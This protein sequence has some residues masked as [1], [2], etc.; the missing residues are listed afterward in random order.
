VT[1]RVP[2]KLNLHLGVHAARPDGFH[3]LH[4]VF[5]AVA[6]FDQVTA[7]ESRGLSLE[8][9]GDSDGVPGDASNLAWRAAELLAGEAGVRPDVHLRVHKAIPVAGGMAGGSADA[10]GALV[11]CAALWGVEAD[12]P[13]LAARLGSDVAFPLLGGTAVGTGRGEVLRPVACAPLHWVLAL[14]GFGISAGDAY[15]ELDRLRAAGAAAAPAGP[16]PDALLAAL[17]TGD[18]ERIGALLGN[19]LQAA[20][21]S[22]VPELSRTLELGL[23]AGAVAGIVS[24]SGPTCAFLCRSSSHAAAVAAELDAASVRVVAAHGPVPGATLLSG[25]GE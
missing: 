6:L 25:G 4:T 17:P 5:H 15:R 11:A 18:V 7:C 12:V 19:D 20:A 23:S 3:D 10:A 13:T 1:V 2:A 21:L 14:A 9:T 16:D 24:G 8:V 22:L